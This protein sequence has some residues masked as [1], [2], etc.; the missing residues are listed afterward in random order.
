MT[1]SRREVRQFAQDRSWGGQTSWILQSGSEGLPSI[2]IKREADRS[3]EAT[4]PQGQRLAW[5]GHEPRTLAAPRSWRSQGTDSPLEPLGEDRPRRHL[6]S[7][8]VKMT[9]DFWPPELQENRL[10]LSALSLSSFVTAATEN[11]RRVEASQLG[12]SVLKYRNSTSNCWV[13]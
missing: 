7:G 4:W 6:D 9:S 11:E 5:W 10:P 13:K 3:R 12:Q 1:V 8:P 2:L